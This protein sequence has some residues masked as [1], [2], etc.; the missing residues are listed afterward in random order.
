MEE[1]LWFMDRIIDK[2]LVGF[3]GLTIGH[4]R[5]AMDMRKVGFPILLEV[6]QFLHNGMVQVVDCMAGI[7]GQRHLF[8]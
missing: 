8:M 7:K 5:Q 1:Q 2:V 3:Q 4:G 6:I